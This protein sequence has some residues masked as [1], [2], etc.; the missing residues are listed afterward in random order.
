MPSTHPNRRPLP[1]LLALLLCLPLLST[2]CAT[3]STKAS[4]A[5]I[6][7]PTLPALPTELVRTER[8]KPLDEM[9]SGQLVSIDRSILTE[10]YVRLAET[11]AAVE[12]GNNRAA[13]VQRWWRCIDAIWQTGKT[14]AECS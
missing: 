4:R 10:L 14:P 8:V 3:A 6:E 1:I 12:R 5:R 9:A 11:A 13:G 7:R 2:G